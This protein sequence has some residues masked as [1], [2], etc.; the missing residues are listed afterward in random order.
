MTPELVLDFFNW[1]VTESRHSYGSAWNTKQSDKI[2]QSILKT[3]EFYHQDDFSDSDSGLWVSWKS[4]YFSKPFAY[5]F[6]TSTVNK[7]ESDKIIQAFTT[8]FE[9]QVSRIAKRRDRKQAKYYMQW[10]FQTMIS[11]IF[12]CCS[13]CKLVKKCRLPCILFNKKCWSPVSQK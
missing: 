10:D 9:V 13:V 2:W 8:G 1:S 4:W 6:K 7:T 5:K 3:I 12:L 11:C